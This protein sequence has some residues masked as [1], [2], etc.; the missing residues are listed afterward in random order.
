MV[1]SHVLC[2]FLLHAVE[3]EIRHAMHPSESHSV[4]V[5]DNV[6]VWHEATNR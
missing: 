6:M 1:S 4:E 5:L 3:V 2:S